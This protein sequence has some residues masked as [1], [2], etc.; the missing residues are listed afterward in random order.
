[1]KFLVFCFLLLIVFE[2][3]SD[4]PDTLKLDEVVI[5]ARRSP[6]VHSESAR[7]VH[8]LQR[9]EI[10][11]I[12]ARSI[13]G[14]LEYVSGVDIRKRG[15]QGVQSDVSIRGGSFDQALILING[16]KINDPQTG[17]HNLNI[18]VN[19]QDIKRIEVLAGPGSRIFGANAFSGAVNIITVSDKDQSVHTG[20]T[21]GEFGL[22]N[23]RASLATGGDNFSNFLTYNYKTSNG[24]IENTDFNI[25]NLF[26]HGN[27]TIGS[28]EIDGQAG[29]QDKAFGAN[30]FYSSKFAE[31]FEHT[32]AKFASLKAETGDK[33]KISPVVYWRRHHDRFE[34]FRYEHE[35][36]Y[37]GHNYHQTDVYGAELNT[38]IKTSVGKTSLGAEIRSEN[39]MSNVL[40]EPKDDSVKVKGEPHGWFTHAK[41]RNNLGLFAE[42][43]V[44]LNQ[45]VI[46]GGAFAHYNNDFGIQ[47]YPGIDI[48]YKA[49]NNW[50]IF[51]SYNHAMRTPTFTDLY[52]KGPDRKGNPELEPEKAQSVETGVKFMHQ[53]F[54]GHA[55]IFYRDAS[56]V[57]DWVKRN[58]AEFWESKNITNVISSGF[59]AKAKIP[60]KNILSKNQPFNI[61]ELSYNYTYT[62][63]DAGDFISNYALDFLKHKFISKLNHNILNDLS[64]SWVLSFNERNGAYFHYQRQKTMPYKSFWILDIKLN[65]RYNNITSFIEANN[66]FNKEYIDFGNIIQPGRWIK[67]GLNYKL[68]F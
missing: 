8:V 40:G 60:L 39:I 19:P 36:F 32:R 43:T 37:E 1:M 45:F 24:Y 3:K 68:D 65:H 63:K 2:V 15:A 34:L 57:I 6:A 58:E 14:L 20:I 21:G 17:H 7:I 56:N 55:S 16:I 31:Q 67:A 18:P 51:S 42:H 25:H 11:S 5:S 26:W 30:S 49:S 64:A 12:P 9:D 52:Y 35:P 33:I 53:L 41:S 13:S 27:T 46:S 50:K 61:L 22:L 66:V 29:Y 10:A 28:V 62:D 23:T 44:F 54:Y 38:S 48:G 47:W 4:N 59:E